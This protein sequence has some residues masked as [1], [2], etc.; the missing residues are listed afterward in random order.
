MVMRMMSILTSPS[1]LLPAL[2][3][4]ILLTF[5]LL[6]FL[7]SLY[8]IVILIIIM[9]SNNSYGGTYRLM[10]KVATKQGIHVKYVNMAGSDGPANLAAAITPITRIVMIESPTNPMQRICDIK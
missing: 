8:I 6:A 5:H 4:H 1:P 7:I 9:T 10:S 2:S 3:I